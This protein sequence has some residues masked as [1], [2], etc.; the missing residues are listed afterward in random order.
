M[1]KIQCLNQ[2][3]QF[4]N[5]LKKHKLNDD[6]FTIYYG[7]NNPKFSESNSNLNIS[8]VIKKKTGNAVKRNKIRRKLKS[9]V[10]KILTD[11]KTINLNYTYV[12]FGKAKAYEEKYSA[13]LDKVQNAFKKIK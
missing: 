1:I 12:V 4:L 13:I 2:N 6:F 10:Q 7:K 8:F 11:N 9:A 5:I 3:R